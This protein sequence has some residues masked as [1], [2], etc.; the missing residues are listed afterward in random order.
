MNKNDGIIYNLDNKPVI[1]AAMGEFLIDFDFEQQK[2]LKCFLDDG[3][4]VRGFAYL[5]VSAAR[6]KVLYSYAKEDQYHIV[7]DLDIWKTVHTDFS[8]VQFEL[9]VQA[10]Y[11][12]KKI[13]VAD[14]KNANMLSIQMLMLIIEAAENRIDISSRLNSDIEYDII[15]ADV[16]K[17]I[18]SK[19]K[20]DKLKSDL[21]YFVV[22]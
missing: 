18:K 3:F 15:A 9:A 19:N 12:G 21:L 22:E 6:M 1:N 17:K 5:G 16:N 10:L 2:I 14:I 7:T 4:S 8:D 11:T 13:V 20:L